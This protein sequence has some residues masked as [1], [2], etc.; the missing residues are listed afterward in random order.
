MGLY[1]LEGTI[2]R[3]GQ[4]EFDN[5]IVVYAYIEFVD[6]HGQRTL[7]KK[8][9]VCVDIQAAIG[10]G[11]DGT[12]YFDELFVSGRRYLCQLWGLRNA[13]RSILDGADLRRILAIVH[14]VR[15]I[16]FT[17]V[18]AVG[19]PDLI[20][21]VGQTWSLMSGSAVRE[22]FFV[23]NDAA[24]A[25]RGLLYNDGVGAVRPLPMPERIGLRLREVALDI[26]R[27]RLPYA[28][29]R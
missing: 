5:D 29:K 13:E 10:E 14:L 22:K 11:V 19:L 24:S 20:A 16:L 4:C 2:S 3:L 15:G 18:F 7:V 25:P 27:K 21:G 28:S 17:P 9:A 6:A 26:Y 23:R 1:R 12:F 8:V